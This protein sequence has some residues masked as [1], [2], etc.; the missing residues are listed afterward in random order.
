MMKYY[1]L[2]DFAGFCVGHKYCER[3]NAMNVDL[4]Q[5]KES[6]NL[7]GK[8]VAVLATDGFEQSELEVPVAALK[9]CGADV[10]I[11]SPKASIRGW[12]DENWGKS[13]TADCLLDEARSD[14]YDSLVLPGGVMNSDKLRTFSKAVV[15]T[16]SFF[17][18]KKPVAAICHAGQILIEAGVVDGRKMTSYAS[19]R[20]DLENAGAQWIDQSV[21][22][23]QGFT[24]SRSPEDLADFCDKMCEEI[25]E[26]IH[27]A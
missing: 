19:I 5:L 3:S 15:F 13:W 6:Y 22:V 23:D 14:D 21:V 24:T 4:Q 16:R 20:M 11:I 9:A 18:Q 2:Y 25:Q 12:D 10:E 1:S 27:R 8:R 26:G 7:T 17:D